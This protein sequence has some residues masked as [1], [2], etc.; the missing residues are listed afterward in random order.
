MTAVNG[1]RSRTVEND[2]DGG[3]PYLRDIPWIGDKLFG[4][5]TRTKEQ[6]EIIVFVTVGLCDADTIKSDAGLPKN[7]VL[8]R[9]YTDG[10]RQEPGDR[11]NAVEGVQSLDLR[12]LEERAKETRRE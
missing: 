3:I 2:A 7:A 1:G 4:S 12:D 10:T 5:K 9:G 6:R 11:K 8:G